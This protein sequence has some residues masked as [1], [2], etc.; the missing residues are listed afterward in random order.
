MAA[1]L[2]HI[3]AT[4][5]ISLLVPPIVIEARAPG[6]SGRSPSAQ[7]QAAAT[8][9]GST[10]RLRLAGR[11]GVIPARRC[12][13][14]MQLRRHSRKRIR[15]QRWRIGLQCSRSCNAGSEWKI[16]SAPR[17]VAPVPRG[18]VRFRRHQHTAY[19][20]RAAVGSRKNQ[21]S[22]STKKQMN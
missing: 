16:A 9:G 19:F 14:G 17:A 21:G 13:E 11:G 10:A 12:C 1:R 18:D 22:L 3:N 4:L 8:R 7:R 15:R 5:L 6:P 20:H 2:G